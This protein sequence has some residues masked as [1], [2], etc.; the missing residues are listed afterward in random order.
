MYRNTLTTITSIVALT[1][2]LVFSQVV[3]NEIHYNPSTAQG[4]DWDYEFM[5]LYNAGT[6]TVD[7]SGWSFSQGVIH[8]FADGTT[9]AAGAYMIVDIDIANAGGELDASPYDPDGDGLHENGAQ[10]V[11]WTGNNLSNGGEDIEIL[12]SLGAPIDF[13]D[14]E[15]GFNSFGNWGIWHDGRGSSLELIDAAVPN[16][17]AFAWQGSWVVGG[18]PGA[19]NS[20]EPE[21]MVATIYNTQITTAP[22]GASAMAGEY[23]VSEASAWSGRL[24]QCSLLLFPSPNVGFS[25]PSSLR[26]RACTERAPYSRC[27]CCFSWIAHV[28][29]YL[30]PSNAPQS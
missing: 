13:V 23:V 16:D 12:D 4:S 14:Y 2:N 30:H 21:A 5:E 22:N 11:H 25:R 8:T 19:A 27:A 1:V 7:M 17:S 10:V 3:I 15:D 29:C 20:T 24:A 18:T 9:L 6:D 28:Q 26:L